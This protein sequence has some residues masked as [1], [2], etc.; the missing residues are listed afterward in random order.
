MSHNSALNL[1]DQTTDDDDHRYM[2]VSTHTTSEGRLAYQRCTCGVWRVQRYPR[3]GRPVIEAVVVASPAGVDAPAV[4]TSCAAD[5]ALDLGLRGSR[6]E[7]A[8]TV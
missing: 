1:P 5:S 8:A 3:R 7:S 2:V 4:L 6:I